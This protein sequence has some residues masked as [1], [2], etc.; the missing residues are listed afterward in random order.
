LHCAVDGTLLFLDVSGFTALSERLAKR[1]PVG[2][3]QLTTVMDTVFGTMIDLAATRGGRL[4]SFGGD[5]LLL[6]FSG[7]DHAMQAT[8]AGVEL[9]ASLASVTSQPTPAGRV[10]ARVSMG[11]HSGQVHLFLVGGSHRELV[12]SGPAATAVARLEAAAQAGQIMVSDATADAL[13]PGSVGS[14]TGTGRPLRWRHPRA[15]ASGAVRS[16]ATLPTWVTEQP[17]TFVPTALRRL[18]AAGD[19]DF[20]HRTVGISFVRYA[21]MDRALTQEGPEAASA[22]LHELVLTAQQAADEH[23]V[24]FLATDLAPDGGK[25]IIVAGFPSADVDDVG[26]LLRVTR[27]T[28][29]AT[30]CG[31]GPLSASAGVNRGHVFAGAV[32]S[33]TH[34]ALT[35]MGDTVNLAARVMGVAGPGEVL[36]TTAALEAA[37]TVFETTA[38][39]PFL[40]K[41]KRYPV[42]AYDVGPPAGRRDT[43]AAATLPFVGR[44]EELAT[45][46]GALERAKDGQGCVVTITGDTGIGKTRLATEAL[47]KSG[48]K[49]AVVLHPEPYGAAIPYRMWREPLRDVLG[50]SGVERDGLGAA[51]HDAI[52]RHHPDLLGWLPLLGDV[53]GI[54][55]VGSRQVDE[56]DPKFR[57]ARTADVVLEVLSRLAPAPLVVLAEDAHWADDAGGG[58]LA[59]LERA[60]ETGTHNVALVVS[61]R[62]T[63]G[64]FVPSSS[65]A[66][67][68]APLPEH[69]VKDLVAR[70]MQAVPLLPSVVHAVMSRVAGNPLFLEETL[71]T[72]RES[73]SL[74]ALPDSLDALMSARLDALAL[75]AR[76]LARLASVLGTSFE[77]GLLI[78]IAG[79]AGVGVPTEDPAI[80]LADVCDPMDGH[81][82]FRHALLHDAA[83]RGMPFQ[84]RRE[85]HLIA[86]R[87]LL[88]RHVEDPKSVADEL[89]LHYALGGDVRRTWQW[90]CLAADRANLRYANVEAAQHYRRAL[91]ACRRLPDVQATERRRVW[92]ALGDVLTRD[93]RFP[94]ALAAYR[95]ALAFATEPVDQAV[96]LAMTARARERAGRYVAA[97]RDLTKAERLLVAHPGE[98]GSANGVDP[99]SRVQAMRSTVRLAQGQL[100][101]AEAAAAQAVA[102]AE[103]A[104]DEIALARALNVLGSAMAMQGRPGAAPPLRRASE[105]YERHGHR[106]DQAAITGNLGALA[107]YD[108]DWEEA[109]RLYER[110][111]NAGERAGDLVPAALAAANLGEL[112]VAQGRFAEAV[113]ILRQ[114]LAFM[115]A[116]G[117]LDG[118]ALA[119]AQL[120][121]ALTGTEN[122]DDARALLSAARQNLV[123]LQ[124]A[125]VVELAC[126]AAELEVDAGDPDA[127]AAILNPLQHLGAS[128]LGVYSAELARVRVRV[129]ARTGDLVSA[130][131]ILAIGVATAD[132]EG[133]GY[134]RA[135]LRL[136]A[137]ELAVCAGEKVDTEEISRATVELTALGVLPLRVAS[138]V[139]AAAPETISTVL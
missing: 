44:A 48:L 59:R 41:G 30:Y 69:A 129:A 118:I 4:L 101:Q 23:E 122:F 105:I 18:L 51:L 130:A 116:A 126:A 82:R 111:A 11:V 79:Q 43:G 52:T 81:L 113:P 46:V 99:L 33:R 67:D 47:A 134:E 62:P 36:A 70:A 25:V 117:Y 16:M 128:E 7:A 57:P 56:L 125:D 98:R 31:T 49:P 78:D 50:L 120:G 112:L 37:N 124:V 24:T 64:G 9:R 12:V 35:V 94:E 114:T 22:A 80:V 127:A 55:T 86:A 65:T 108:G 8:S 95:A 1:G 107:W 72:L 85:L 133:L 89:A 71:R 17:E 3:E 123:G 40:V 87:V 93:G 58:L 54:P 136:A 100:R 91:E 135:R 68:L 42:T 106:A 14:T 84:R 53:L 38:L 5:A 66:I 63:E 132:R 83:Y 6:L 29:L 39:A 104:G 102:T 92:T 137:Q 119:T 138:L 19:P 77:A 96:V 109:R 103:A 26:R 10:N 131:E 88:R 32:G 20:E 139:A 45:V 28:V 121:R 27:R 13:P 74:E 75:P 97:H 2:A 90:A 73:G 115:S 15:P 76:R 34:A 21:G 110:A 60:V 61:R